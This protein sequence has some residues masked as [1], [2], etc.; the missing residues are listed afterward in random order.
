MFGRLSQLL[1]LLLTSAG[2]ASATTPV[3]T[4]TSPAPGASTGSPVNF[5]ASASSSACAKG[6][7]AMRI[8]TASGVNA[9]T[10]NANSLNANINLPIGSYSA[11]VQAWDNCGGVGKTTVNIKVSKINLAPPKFL[12]ATEY[13]A[14]RIGE[15]VVNPLTGS[16]TPTSQKWAWA[17][18]GPVGIASD[19]GGFRLYVTNYGSHD[20]DAYFIN[21]SNGSLTQVPG[22]PYPLKGIGS[23]VVVHPSGHFVYATS[24]NFNTSTQ[25]SAFMVQ[26]NGSLTA[27]PGSPFSESSPSIGA[28]AMDP[29]GKYLFASDEASGNAGAVEVYDINEVNG[30]LTPIPGSPFETASYPGCTQF[31]SEEPTDLQVD[32]SGKYL[33]GAQ[34]TQDAVV[35]FR[36][37]PATGTL[38]NLP[39]SPYAEGR[40][41]TPQNCCANDPST[42]SIA[43]NGKFLYAANDEGDSFSVY[44]LNESTGVLSFEDTIGNVCTPTGYLPGLLDPYTVAVDPS[45][46]F[47]YTEGDTV[48][49]C[50]IPPGTTG[51]MAGYSIS[52]GNGFL[53][54][55]PGNPFANSDIHTT[56]ISVEKVVV[57][58]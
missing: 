27:I 53:M 41:N 48:K 54:S 21:R 4:V 23:H 12:Y 46:S 32:P 10:I 49:G 20:L 29:S 3:V 28:L 6:I 19:A 47:L 36:I 7:S 9:Y 18:W 42:L 22:S 50:T 16:L 25:I 52:Q 8:Y 14:G 5:V 15:Y 37:D 1:L 44:R 31:C 24:T 39:G 56:N 34:A 30:A 58:K 2:L 33:Y 57:T 43:P 13:K 40:F 11:V 26:S 38:T 17:H 45:G 51:A 55:V 35:A